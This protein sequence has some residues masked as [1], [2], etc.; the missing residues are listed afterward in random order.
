MSTLLPSRVA[1]DRF[2]NAGRAA[3]LALLRTRIGQLPGLTVLDDPRPRTRRGDLRIVI[4]VRGTGRSGYEIGR[5][6]RRFSGLPLELCREHRL[7]V[8]FDA[9]EEI[10]ARSER[11][12]L[13]LA[14]ACQ[15]VVPA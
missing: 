5:R 8:V 13:A 3:S 11:L 4:D 10:G 6:M 7:V 14:H 12:L 2:V 9:D 1:S 15:D